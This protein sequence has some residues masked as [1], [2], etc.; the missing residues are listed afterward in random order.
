MT[1]RASGDVR[2]E[3]TYDLSPAFSS[4]SSSRLLDLLTVCR[5]WSTTSDPWKQ[6]N[7]EACD[8]RFPSQVEEESRLSES[9][10]QAAIRSNR[11]QMI[12]F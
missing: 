9:E 4:V 7:V 2:K 3:E 6:N 11:N 12:R 10:K 8:Q 1:G 5:T